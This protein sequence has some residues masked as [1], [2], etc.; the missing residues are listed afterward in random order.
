MTFWIGALVRQALCL[1]LLFMALDSGA[2]TLTVGYFDLPPHVLPQGTARNSPAIA[3]FDQVAAKMGVT[4][5]YQHYPLS[6][7][8]SELKA[9]KIDAALILAKNPERV[10]FLDYPS[11][12]FLVTTPVIVVRQDSPFQTEEQL[13]A[14]SDTLAIGIWHGGYQS[15]IMTKLKGHITRLSG[16]NVD[17]RG[18]NMV[19]L[20]RLDAFYCPDILSVQNRSQNSLQGRPVRLI[21]IP[22]DGLALYTAFSRQ[23]GRLYKQRYE[24]SL[25]ATVQQE[26]YES[27]LAHTLT[28]LPR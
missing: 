17:Q 5:V 10:A 16:D 19:S 15:R 12:P 21:P 14:H 20:G 13:Q 1:V 2:Q 7:L 18:V 3:Y 11:Q 25:A 24:Q 6:R 26:S 8:L 28:N 4:V 9:N 27:F 23:A 22:S